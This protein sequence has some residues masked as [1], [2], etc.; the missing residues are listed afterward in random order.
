MDDEEVYN[1]SEDDMKELK[2]MADKVLK[3]RRC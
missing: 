2:E 1:I 3:E